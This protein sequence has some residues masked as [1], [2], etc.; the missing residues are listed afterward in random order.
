MNPNTVSNPNDFKV[1]D[2]T[3]KCDF[4]FTPEMG[5]MYNGSP[6]SGITGVMGINVG[7]SIKL[8]Y[9]VGQQLALNLAKAA[10]T[11]GAPA[12]DVA[13]VPTGVPL[14]DHQKLESFKNSFL[15]DLYTEQRPVAQSETERLLQMVKDLNATVDGLVQNQPKAEKVYSDKQD[16]I[17]ELEKLGIVHDK[18]KGK[19]DLEKLLT[20]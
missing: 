2:F 12:V 17:A 11:R 15:T 9:H 16:V 18:R 5:C 13:G 7:E 1:V 10:L 3:N 4:V 6:I 20:K 19:E 14:W 8:P